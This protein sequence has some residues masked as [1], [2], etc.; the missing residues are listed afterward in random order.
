MIDINLRNIFIGVS[1]TFLAA[2]SMAMPAHPA[3]AKVLQSDGSELTVRVVG[4][5]FYH[6]TM[7]SDGD[8]VMKS[9]DGDYKYAVA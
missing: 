1:L 4:D 9:P 3:P 6:Y 8:T 5:E 7:T 2:N